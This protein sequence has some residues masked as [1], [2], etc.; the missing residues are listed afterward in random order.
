MEF[1]DKRFVN[2]PDKNKFNEIIENNQ[3]NTIN[4]IEKVI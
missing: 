1:K 3:Q 4:N 2:I